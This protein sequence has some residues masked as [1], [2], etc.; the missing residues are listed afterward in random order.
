MGGAHFLTPGQP[1][2]RTLSRHQR[3]YARGVA[4]T[5]ETHAHGAGLPLPPRR[6]H[7]G[8]ATVTE[9]PVLQGSPAGAPSHPSVSQVPF[10]REGAS[11]NCH[12]DPARKQGTSLELKALQ[13][14]MLPTLEK[15]T[16][17]H[18]F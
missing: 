6:C 9:V 11:K 4:R 15:N 2:I 5:W 8:L 18:P 3:D 13:K 14:R 1:G 7:Q 12:E 10:C 17:K 16:H